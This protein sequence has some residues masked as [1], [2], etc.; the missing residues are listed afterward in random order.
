M[1]VFVGGGTMEWL[2]C[3]LFVEQII[4]GYRVGVVVV[5]GG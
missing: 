2:V 4:G 5:G 3:V 1:G